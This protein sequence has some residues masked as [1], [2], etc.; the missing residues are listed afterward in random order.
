MYLSPQK[1]K[2]SCK[3]AKKRYDPYSQT[4]FSKKQ[5]IHLTA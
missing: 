5:E 1:R 2:K 4:M 3:G